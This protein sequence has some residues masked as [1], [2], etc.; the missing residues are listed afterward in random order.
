MTARHVAF[1][2]DT[3][4]GSKY[5]LMP[6]KIIGEYS[7]I[8]TRSSLNKMWAMWEEYWLWV[9]EKTNGE[10]FI[11]VTMGDMVDGRHPTARNAA[12]LITA[13]LSE[14]VDIAV[15]CSQTF[16]KKAAGV[17]CVM[18]TEAHVGQSGETESEYA[19]RIGSSP[20]RRGSPR[21]ITN[22][23]RLRLGKHLIDCQHHIAPGG[24]TNPDAPLVREYNMAVTVYGEHGHPLPSLIV[25][26]H[27]HEAKKIERW[28]ENVYGEQVW[29]ITT[30]C[31]QLPPPYVGKVARARFQPPH[32]GGALA[33]L[34]DDGT[35][36]V[37]QRTWKMKPDAPVSI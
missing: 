22:R 10:P 14:Q 17:Y 7:S 37:R 25:R 6:P 34:K 27:C 5:G 4:C 36:K 28:N 35:L 18:G 13:D 11:V 32:F 26:G 16:L 24:S 33:S 8:V 29:A 9:F 23:L 30:P 2:G 1:F 21:L 15:A 12:S 31:W 19:S 3:H 20:P